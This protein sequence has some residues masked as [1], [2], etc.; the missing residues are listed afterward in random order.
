MKHDR[1]MRVINGR[2]V[3][4]HRNGETCQR[5]KMKNEMRSDGRILKKKYIHI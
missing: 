3:D 1:S 2:Y 4:A 5:R